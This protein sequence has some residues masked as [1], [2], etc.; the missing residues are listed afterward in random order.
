MNLLGKV[1]SLT[2]MKKKEGPS[3]D[4]LTADKKKVL[5]FF[6]E[7]GEQE[8]TGIQGC[9]KKK[10]GEVIKLRP[11]EGWVDL[12]TKLQQSRGLSTEML[13]SAT[14]LL[15]MKSAVTKLMNKCQKITVKM[16][17]IVEQLTSCSQNMLELSEQP[18]S[19]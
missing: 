14:E 18:K 10:V 9:N 16:E 11:F 12:V 1:L 13:N 19:L 7:G 17:G 3:D 6:N 2:L 15:R 4:N 8:M 5:K